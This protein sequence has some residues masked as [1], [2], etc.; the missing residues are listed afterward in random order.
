MKQKD[1]PNI[2]IQELS[3]K[4][5]MDCSPWLEDYLDC[6]TFKYKPVTEAFIDRISNELLNWAQN[7]NDALKLTEFFNK[8]RIPKSTWEA[9][10]RYPIFKAARALAVEALG[11]RR[12]KGAITRKYDATTINVMMPL[13]DSDWKE[14][15]EWRAKLK[16]ESETAQV[17]QTVIFKSFEEIKT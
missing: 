13:Y 14:N 2:K 4:R 15:V 12:E 5:D 10:N 6:F 17:P 3:Q 1:H 9:W 16:S 7:D 8:K 11:N